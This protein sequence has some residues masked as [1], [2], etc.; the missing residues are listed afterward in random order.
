MA[1]SWF[2]S[3]AFR[4]RDGT[5]PLWLVLILVLAGYALMGRIG[6]A[7]A[8]PPTGTVVLWP[9][10][11]V[12]LTGLL[13]S[14]P[15]HWPFLLAA[16]LAGEVIAGW[17][18]LTLPWALAFG[19]VNGVEATLAAALL[20]R[21]ATGPLRIDGLAAFV[22]YVLVAPFAASAL[23][24]TAGALIIKLR[25]PE[26]GYLHYWRVFW[27]GD[28]LGLLLV[29]TTLLVWLAPRER[30]R[31]PPR[32]RLLEAVALSACL[33]AG[34]VLSLRIAHDL[35]HLYLLFPLL[36]WTALRFRIEGATLAVLAVTAI[37]IR[38]MLDGLGPFTDLA[39]VD[40][41][42]AMQLLIAVVALS[43]FILAVSADERRQV[44]RNLKRSVRELQ[45]ARADLERM[46]ADLD[47]IV[48]ERTRAL[49]STLERNEMLLR[50]VHHRVKNNLQLISSL[51]AL[52]RRGVTEPAMR[53]R[54][55]RIQGQIGAIARTYDLLH[56]LGASEQVDFGPFVPA[57]CE[58][59]E[60]SE[61]GRAQVTPDLQGSAEVTADSAIA[62][63]LALNEL[64]TNALKHGG[65][66]PE[67]RVSCRRERGEL[68]L[69][70]ADDGPGLGEGFDLM[71]QPGFGVRMVAS[72]IG[73][74][75]GTIRTLPAQRGAAIE[76]RVPAMDGTAPPGT[77]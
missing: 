7:T 65:P 72:L 39:E 35:D 37:A 29:G 9:A 41:V 59:I 60:E 49:R 71:A 28:A 36:V 47:G 15:R 46:N 76:I 70:V 73:Q 55:V 18:T 53:E 23:A 3:S 50:E 75:N 51:V 38:A 58:A 42:T 33:I 16:G 67:V 52:Q 31:M 77:P 20:R 12:L 19:L 30:P 45:Q 22:R 44:T 5:A 63:S 64:V 4:E 32:L 1:V 14:S 69:T 61:G 68:V 2:G 62:L 66:E 6:T 27:L 74:V 17:D 11:A 21:L 8:M 48:T 54:M 26:I 10:N 43:T 56:R 40:R 25:F 24:A 34:A 13:F 57:L